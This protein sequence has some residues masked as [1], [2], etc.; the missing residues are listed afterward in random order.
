MVQIVV[1]NGGVGR[2]IA[3][4]YVLCCRIGWM[5]FDGGD[6]CLECV[7]VGPKL[8]ELGDQGLGKMPEATAVIHEATAVI[9]QLICCDLVNLFHL[10]VQARG[11]VSDEVGGSR[12]AFVQVAEDF[13]SRHD[14]LIS[15]PDTLI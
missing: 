12:N 2:S 7:K 3:V 10:C 13:I 9:D 4:S 15:S 5:A 11:S 1:R 14:A 8:G 6:L